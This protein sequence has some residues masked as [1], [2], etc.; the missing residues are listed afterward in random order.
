MYRQQLFED[1]NGTRV[2]FD[3]VIHDPV[4]SEG[5]ET[6]YYCD[7]DAPGLF[8]RPKR[9]RGE[10]AAQAADLAERFVNT[11]LSDVTV[12]DESGQPVRSIGSGRA[13]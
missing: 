9:I 3:L 12:Y 13:F 2:P 10:G 5:S 8:P 7:I 11:R 1:D 6:E 4:R